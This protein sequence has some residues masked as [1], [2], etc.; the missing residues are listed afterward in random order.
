MLALFYNI[1]HSGRTTFVLPECQVAGPVGFEPTIRRLTVSRV[2]L[3][4]LGPIKNG[5]SGRDRTYDL[6]IIGGLL[7]HL[8]YRTTLGLSRDEEGIAAPLPCQFHWDDRSLHL[9]SP[10]IS[11]VGGRLYSVCQRGAGLEA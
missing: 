2:H 4:R 5:C 8:S 3:V 10:V 1:I 7:S 11:P 9:S 6:A